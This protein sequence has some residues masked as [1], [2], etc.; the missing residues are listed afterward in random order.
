M[1]EKIDISITNSGRIRWVENGKNHEKDL[2]P[3]DMTALLEILEKASFMRMDRT[4][5]RAIPDGG[6]RRIVAHV[7]GVQHDVTFFPHADEDAKSDQQRE[8]LKNFNVVWEHLVSL[9]ARE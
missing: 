3:K 5:G 4:Y 7:D 6:F 1:V 2:G 9:S 8:G